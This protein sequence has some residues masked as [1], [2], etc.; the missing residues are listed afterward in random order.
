[1]NRGLLL[2]LLLG[3]SVPFSRGESLDRAIERTEVVQRRALASNTPALVY[4]ELRDPILI[5]M[6]LKGAGGEAADAVISV[7][8][9]GDDSG[10]TV[11]I[12]ALETTSLPDRAIQA[13]SE[14]ARLRWLGVSKE[15]AL[16]LI[17]EAVRRVSPRDEQGAALKRATP[18]LPYERLRPVRAADSLA[19]FWTE[20]G[21]S[22]VFEDKDVSFVI[23]FQKQGE[24]VEAL[25]YCVDSKEFGAQTRASVAEAAKIA[26]SRVRERYGN[27]RPP[28][29]VLFWREL[30]QVLHE[31]GVTWLSPEELNPDI[32][33][34]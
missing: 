6:L 31:R 18:W 3:L 24:A 29:A 21:R 25:V 20:D 1:M 17:G 34:H 2:T 15:A 27:R 9:G 26:S 30:K 12:H 13:V 23:V 19:I 10:F 11:S 7:V 32:D 33:W 16:K 28:S 22:F 8:L 4:R 5:K 14:F